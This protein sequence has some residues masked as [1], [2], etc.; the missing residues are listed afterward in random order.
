LQVAQVVTRPAIYGGDGQSAEAADALA[1]RL[2]AA[3]NFCQGIETEDLAY[4]T[5]EGQLADLKTR[6][7][8]AAGA[9][10]AAE[11]WLI[12]LGGLIGKGTQ[13]NPMG[14]SDAVLLVRDAIRSGTLTEA[15]AVDIQTGDQRTGQ[16]DSLATD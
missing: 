1:H 7:A 10:R 16:V 8:L 11:P 14:R 5:H 4:A 9:L 15:T 13:E 2:V 3:H 12:L 6:L